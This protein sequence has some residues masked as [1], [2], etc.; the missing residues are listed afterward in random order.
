MRT[1]EVSPR[2]TRASARAMSG[3]VVK[4]WARSARTASRVIPLPA[5]SGR[6]THPT[7]KVGGEIQ[8]WRKATPPT[9]RPSISIPRSQRGGR[10]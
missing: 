4:R 3:K 10:P 8:V 1:P 9:R 5:A 6:S 2:R 7:S